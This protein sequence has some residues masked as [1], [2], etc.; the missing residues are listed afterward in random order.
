MRERVEESILEKKQKLILLCSLQTLPED[1]FGFVAHSKTHLIQISQNHKSGRKEREKRRVKRGGEEGR[2]G[3]G[4]GERG[5][6]GY[7]MKS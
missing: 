7:V 6:T 1:L 4:G 2:R 3:G 5:S